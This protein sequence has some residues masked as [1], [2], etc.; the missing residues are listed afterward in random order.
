MSLSPRRSK[1]ILRY[2]AV[3]QRSPSRTALASSKRQSLRETSQSKRE[4]T[5]DVDSYL[6]YMPKRVDDSKGHRRHKSSRSLDCRPTY[7][8]DYQPHQSESKH[9][10]QG[11]YIEDSES[12]SSRESSFF[13]RAASFVD[14][15]RHWHKYQAE[16][17]TIDPESQ[18]QSRRH[19]EPTLTD[20]KEHNIA[21]GRCLKHW[22]P[23][24]EPILLLTSV[25]DANSLGKWVLKQTTRIY[26]EHDEMT[27]LAAEFWFEHIKLGGKIKHAKG[28][29]PQIADPSV[30][31]WV[32][33]FI[34]FG[35]KLVNELGEILKKC[36]QRLLEVTGTNEIP[37]LGHKSVVVFVDT[38]IGRNPA[39]R[40][41]FYDL[42]RS[43]KE[44]NTWFDTDCAKL[45]S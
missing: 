36:E 25:F 5:S 45:L 43:I 32:K 39:Q 31:K 1:S 28:C 40:D 14:N 8:S 6:T 17:G 30:R 16:K 27:D 38:F 18:I 41:A 7:Q 10:R 4:A 13:S 19:R 12:E 29:L 22:D 21:P 24:E 35:D 20:A 2:L 11:S 33:E 26:G 34:T 42:T 9:Q 37:K 23:D 3:A 15:R 44:W